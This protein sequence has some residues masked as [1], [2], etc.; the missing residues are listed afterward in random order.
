MHAMIRKYVVQAIVTA[1]SPQEA[2]RKFKAGEMSCIGTKEVG[3]P[4][5]QSAPYDQWPMWAKALKQLSRHED[6]G[7]GDVVERVVGPVGGDAYKL[8]YK[9][10]FGEDC[11]GCN[12]R[13]G[14]LNVRFPL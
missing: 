13:K 10:T 6:K 14:N 11:V 2:L 5:N 7:L 4:E 3:E 12:K 8:W 1:S 9:T